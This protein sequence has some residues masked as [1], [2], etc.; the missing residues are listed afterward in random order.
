[1]TF[2]GNLLRQHV[3]FRKPVI[4]EELLH[5]RVPNHGKVFN[6]LLGVYLKG[7]I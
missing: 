7:K 2:D 6:T 5:F 4:V 3:E 1:M